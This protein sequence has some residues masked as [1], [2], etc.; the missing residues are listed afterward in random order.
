MTKQGRKGRVSPELV[1]ASCAAILVVYGAG[2]WRTRDEARRLASEAQV[3]R[4]ARP[5][6]RAPVRTEPAVQAPAIVEEPAAPDPAA[7]PAPDATTTAS[8]PA[9]ANAGQSPASSPGVDAVPAASSA[10]SN[11]AP[12]ATAVSAGTPVSTISS[13]G[14]GNAGAASTPLP[15]A[16]AIPQQGEPA[17]DNATIVATV[18]P[19]TPVWRDGRFTGWGGSRHG[20]IQ[21]FVTIKNGKI[22]ESGILTCDTRYPCDVIDRILNQPVVWQSAEVDNVSRAT[23]SAGAYYWG[24]VEALKNAEGPP[25]AATASATP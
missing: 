9:V 5:E 7:L 18:G 4:A 23:E 13:A 21:A 2:L 8:S 1:G 10:V 6:R 3:P 14:A 19:P 12:V 11:E 24:L 20:D 17:A 25:D 16:A 15:P 22:V